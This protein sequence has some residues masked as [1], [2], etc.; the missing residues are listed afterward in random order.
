VQ[1]ANFASGRQQDRF[2]LLGARSDTRREPE[3][4][5][6]EFVSELDGFRRSASQ[7]RLLDDTSMHRM[8]LSNLFGPAGEAHRDQ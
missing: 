6:R 8:P 3:R 1:R 2:P 4:T 7:K 5:V